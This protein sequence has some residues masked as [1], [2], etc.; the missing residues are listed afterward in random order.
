MIDYLEDYGVLVWVCAKRL[1]MLRTSSNVKS[2]EEGVESKDDVSMKEFFDLHTV[3][4]IL[5]GSTKY[6]SSPL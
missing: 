3:G 4:E 5:F 1:V 2:V 6:S